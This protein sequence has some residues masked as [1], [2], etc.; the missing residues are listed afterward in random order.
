[1]SRL[2]MGVFLH[3]KRKA[4]LDIKL[5]EQSIKLRRRVLEIVSKSGRG[6]IGP[7]LSI[8]EI[9]NTLYKSI[10][11][12]ALVRENSIDRDRFILSK[13]HGCLALYV[14]L[15]EY[16]LLS[17]MDPSGFCSYDSYFPG[18]PESGAIRA[19][20]F[21]TGSLGHGLA[22]GVGMSMAA[23]LQN[24]TSR[25]FVLLG[26]G[27]MNEGSVWESAAHAT[28]H[29][30][31][32]LVVIVDLNSMQAFGPTSSVLNFGDIVKKWE[33]FGFSVQEINGHD[34]DEIVESINRSSSTGSPTCVIAHTVKGKGIP[35]AENSVVWHHKSRITSKDIE[36]LTMGLET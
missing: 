4:A 28:K 16:D 24:R 29:R 31:D 6:H 5:E 8:L 3:L 20:E 1:M 33:S 7:T 13:G 14:V 35:E 12:K 15:E 30:L 19:I 9:V 11:D 18:H 2:G 36:R 17:G 25:V 26:D 34:E 27:E 22:V 21:S 23:R 10:I 32:N